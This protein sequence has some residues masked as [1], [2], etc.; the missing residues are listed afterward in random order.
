MPKSNLQKRAK[1]ILQ[2][3]EEAFP[4]ARLELDFET[5]LQLLVA[6]ILAAQCTDVRV[7]KVT[8]TLFK[9]YRRPQD[10]L[11]VPEEELQEDIRS[12]GFYRQ[13]ADK[14]RQT[15][16][17]LIE[18]HHAQVPSSMKELTG[19][20]GVGRKTANVILGNCFGIAGI[21]VDTHM[22]RLSQRLE[23]TEEKNPVKIEKALGNLL[24]EKDW[25]RFS[26]TMILHGRYTCKARKPLC[27]KCNLPDQCPYFQEVV[28][29]GREE[30]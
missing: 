17:A 20:P 10:Y 13:K 22:T 23:L 27:G 14:I 9:K 8:K 2:R 4:D 21:V 25:I 28:L 3:L 11:A 19:L 26:L 16:N 5:P 18:S 15:M 7:N 30:S 29:P 1:I 12:T 6:T 24:P